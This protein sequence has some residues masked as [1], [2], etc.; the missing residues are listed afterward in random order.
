MSSHASFG[1]SSLTVEIVAEAGRLGKM[2]RAASS[3][4]RPRPGSDPRP[5]RSGQGLERVAQPAVQP[6]NASRREQPAS[7]RLRRKQ[8]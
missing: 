3:P 4:V 8:P 2:A 7:G 6:I 5:G 1:S